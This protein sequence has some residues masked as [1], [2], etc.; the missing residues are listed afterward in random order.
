MVPQVST[1]TN[2]V[3]MPSSG[4][5]VRHSEASN[6]LTLISSQEE[7]PI[8]EAFITI[9]NRLTALK[10]VARIVLEESGIS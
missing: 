2:L 9:R 4:V 7:L 10:K 5:P 8:L 6:Y 1:E 3:Y